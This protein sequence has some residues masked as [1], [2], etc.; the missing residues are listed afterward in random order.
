MVSY[1]LDLRH[2]DRTSQAAA[3]ELPIRAGA[4][5]GGK[6]GTNPADALQQVEAG[7]PVQ[8]QVAAVKAQAEHVSNPL[9]FESN[10]GVEHGG[11]GDSGAAGSGREE[12]STTT[13]S[14]EQRKLDGG[15]ALVSKRIEVHGKGRGIVVGIEKTKGK[16]SL[17]V[18]EFD[19]GGREAL[20][21]SKDPS[22]ASAKGHKFWLLKGGLQVRATQS[23]S[24]C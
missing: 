24:Q 14:V 10:P 23:R 17:H 19:A 21:L 11:A 8:V 15:A 6:G 5:G 7:K 3:V 9:Q 13:H 20:L 1:Y 16:S 4:A 2:F 22:S 18:V 12:R